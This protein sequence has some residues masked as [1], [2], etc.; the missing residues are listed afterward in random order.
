MSRCCQRW[1]APLV[2]GAVTDAN[3][4][5]SLDDTPNLGILKV[6]FMGY[7]KPYAEYGGRKYDKPLYY[8]EIDNTLELSRSFILGCDINY[9]TSGDSDWDF[10]YLH[11]DFGT[12]IYA[13]KTLLH[14]KLRIKF[15][16]T[17]VFNTSRERWDKCTNGIMLEKWNDAGRRTVGLTVTYRFNQKKNKY[18]GETAT[19]ELKRL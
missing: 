1:T 19:D 10:A 11:D 6:S 7:T 14:D 9:N 4:T 8:F 15:S 12:D 5:F 17:N 3:G 13:V 16:V 2:T 18:K